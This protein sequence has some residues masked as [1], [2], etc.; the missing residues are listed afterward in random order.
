MIDLFASM[1]WG[2]QYSTSLVDF[3]SFFISFVI[4]AVITFFFTIAA[5]TFCKKCRQ[6]LAFLMFALFLICSVVIGLL[7]VL[8]FVFYSNIITFSLANLDRAY[9][10]VYLFKFLLAPIGT[11]LLYDAQLFAVLLLAIGMCSKPRVITPAAVDEKKTEDDYG[12]GEP[13]TVDASPVVVEVPAKKPKAEKAKAKKVKVEKVEKVEKKG[14][15]VVV[16]QSDDELAAL[17]SSMNT[18]LI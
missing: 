15:E 14:V 3:I 1:L 9:V 10:W 5:F 6:V 8:T 11:A 16:E 13:E 18:T 2:W 4:A 7:I 12:E 17:N